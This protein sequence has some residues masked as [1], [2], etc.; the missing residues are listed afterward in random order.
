MADVGKIKED[1]KFKIDDLWDEYYRTQDESHLEA[2][3]D[4]FDRDGSGQIECKEVKEILMTMNG[5]VREEQV[6]KAMTD[7]DINQDG[8]LDRAEF[9]VAMK[10][11]RLV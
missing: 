11:G 9:V 2:I 10:I 4:I 6:V 8:H 5:T 3:F 1:V 7:N